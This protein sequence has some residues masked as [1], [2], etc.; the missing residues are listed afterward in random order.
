MDIVEHA[1]VTG[2]LRGPGGRVKGGRLAGRDPR[3]EGRA[4]GRGP[5]ERARIDGRLRLPPVASLQ[6]LV[7]ALY[8]P[9]LDCVVMSNK[10]HVYV[11][12]A[13]K[14]EP[15]DGG[16]DRRVQRIRATWVVPRDRA[17]ARGGRRALP[18]LRARQAAADV[19]GSSTCP[20]AS[21]I[22]GLSGIDG[23]FLNCGWGTGGFKATPGGM[24][25]RDTIATGESHPI[26]CALLAGTVHDRGVDRRARRRG[27]RA[28]RWVMEGHRS[29]DGARAA[30][31]TGAGDLGAAH[32]P[33]AEAIFVMFSDRE[34]EAG[35]RARTTSSA[36]SS[37]WIPRRSSSRR[38]WGRAAGWAS[39]PDGGSGGDARAGHRGWRL[40]APKRVALRSTAR[41]Q[42]ACRS[43][44]RG[45]GLATRPS[46]TTAA[47]A[48]RVPGG[49]G[50]P[51]RREWADFL[52]RATTRAVRSGSAAPRARVPTLVQRCEGHLNASVHRDV[53]DR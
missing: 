16:G 42:D 23:L 46:F 27:G 18:D 20:D 33:G 5:H 2:F 24:G 28:L 4:R 50:R 45:A 7:S 12:Q 51:V 15:R 37:R 10:V 53:P 40:T 30:G 49:S 35:S 44:A 14:G 17:A 34:R 19:G 6:A 26:S 52:W 38:T 36:H 13:D 29:S 21:P 47:G 48:H 25:V 39:V 41:G 43:A 22:V 1:E 32:V 9:V 31:G 8:E 3:G 11:S